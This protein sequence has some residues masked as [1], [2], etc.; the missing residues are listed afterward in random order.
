MESYGTRVQKSAFEIRVNKR[1]FKQ[2]VSGIP[3]YV[4]NED[5]VKLYKI[6]GNGEVMCW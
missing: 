2:M 6:H 3:Q 4:S 1:L 5:S